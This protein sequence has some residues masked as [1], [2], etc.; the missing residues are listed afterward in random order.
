[1]LTPTLVE[2]LLHLS[3]A[4]KISLGISSLPRWLATQQVTNIAF[5]NWATLPEMTGM[6]DEDIE[7]LLL[8]WIDRTVSE[9]AMIKL[10]FPIFSRM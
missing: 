3:F 1:M 4:I 10:L 6:C 8:F 7:K 9:E 5:A 2:C